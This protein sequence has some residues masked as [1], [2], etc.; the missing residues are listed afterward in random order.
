MVCYVRPV[1]RLAAILLVVFAVFGRPVRG[2]FGTA[3]VMAA[4][5]VA[6]AGAALAAALVFA[7]VLATR[8]R[9]AAAGGCVTCRFQCQHAMTGVRGRAHLVRTVDRAG[10]GR[11]AAAGGPGPRTLLPIQPVAPPYVRDKCFKDRER[12]PAGAGP[13]WPDRPIHRADQVLSGR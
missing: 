11:G 3:D 4:V 12:V 5:A 2:F 8:R 9:R 6:I 7:V 13:R 1:S 10:A